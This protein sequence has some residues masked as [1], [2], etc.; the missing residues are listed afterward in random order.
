LALVFGEALISKGRRASSESRSS[1]SVCDRSGFAKLHIAQ[2][3]RER[4][5]SKRE[6]RERPEGVD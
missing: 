4:V 3:K 1:I 2:E 6:H 5:G